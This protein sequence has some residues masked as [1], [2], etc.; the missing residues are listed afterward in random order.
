MKSGASPSVRLLYLSLLLVGGVSS[1]LEAG[2]PAAIDFETPTGWTVSLQSGDT[3]SGLTTAYAHS[4]SA[5]LMVQGTSALQFTD[6]G[7]WNAAPGYVGLTFYSRGA[8][9]PTTRLWYFGQPAD[10]WTKQEYLFSTSLNW[11]TDIQSANGAPVYIDDVHAEYLT[12]AQAAQWS[13]NHMNSLPAPV[14]IPLSSDRHVYLPKSMA[15]LQAGGTLNVVT[16]GDSI[17]GDTSGSAWTALIERDYPGAKI[18]LTPSVIGGGGAGYYKQEGNVQTYVLAYNPDV[19][20]IGGISND[21]AESV[22]EVIRQ[23]HASSNAE[24]IL[25]NR[26]AGPLDHYE[27]ADGSWSQTIDPNG[28]DYRDQLYKVAIEENVGYI[29]LSWAWQR[30]LLDLAAVGLDENFL[31]RDA[32]HMNQNGQEVVAHAL[33]QFFSPVIATPEPASLGLLAFG[34]LLLCRRRR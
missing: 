27:I 15:T 13:D 20:L 32:L 9:V 21:S 17:V 29:D 11:G 34:S 1:P 18:N 33:E 22:R 28:T 30:Y 5:S 8:G 31:K 12:S 25:M 2:L 14:H 23:I 10:T 26:A 24:I 19:V 7:S 3:Q 4:G 16:L 6:S